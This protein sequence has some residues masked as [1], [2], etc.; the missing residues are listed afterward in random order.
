MN[1]REENEKLEMKTKFE[2]TQEY[3]NIKQSKRNRGERRKKLLLL[4]RNKDKKK[5]FKSRR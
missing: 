2:E 1:K 3:T 5:F 4:K